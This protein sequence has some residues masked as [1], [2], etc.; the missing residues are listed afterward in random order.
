M[1]DIGWGKLQAY[2]A[3]G[4]AGDKKEDFDIVSYEEALSDKY[5]SFRHASHSMLFARNDA[6]L[7]ELYNCRGAVLMQMRFDGLLGFPGGLVDPGENPLQ[8]AN[9]ELEEEIGLDMQKFKLSDRDHVI[10]FVNKSKTLVLH[11][12]GREV[13]LPQFQE[14]ELENL[15]A[16]DYGS[17]TL[18]IVRPPLFTMGDGYRGLPAF[19]SN[20]FAGNA[21]QELLIGLQHYKLL[22]E[23]EIQKAVNSWLIFQQ[24]NK[25]T[26][27]VTNLEN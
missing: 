25:D 11:F 1:T 22:P 2:E 23:D 15:K 20:S 21:R 17:E 19:L 10:S 27:G 24:Q 5:A 7:W 6:I 14:I 9:R 12:Y 8:A 16:P 3:Y 18:G 26:I 4:R 13:T